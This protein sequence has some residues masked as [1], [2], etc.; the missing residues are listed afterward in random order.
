MTVS[1]VVAVTGVGALAGLAALPAA[2]TLVA[3]IVYGADVL[4][5]PR[6]LLVAFGLCLA[7]L[8]ASDG[9]SRR[10]ARLEL[11]QVLRQE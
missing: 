3:G 10:A 5:W 9:P 7:A 4:D 6:A 11:A 2:A 8:A 1:D